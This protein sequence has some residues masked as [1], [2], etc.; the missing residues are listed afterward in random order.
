M[1]RLWREGIK[2]NVVCHGLTSSRPA[3]AV[4]DDQPCPCLRNF[5]DA[6]QNS[7]FSWRRLSP[8]GKRRSPLDMPAKHVVP[9]PSNT[10]V[11]ATSRPAGPL[12]A[13]VNARH[14]N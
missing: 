6:L 4:D 10:F 14:T 2:D 7:A 8:A 1:R 13:T 9:S 3:F 5:G 12:G 11:K